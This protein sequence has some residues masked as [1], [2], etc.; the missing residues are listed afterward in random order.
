MRNWA[1]YDINQVR[2]SAQL[3]AE[4]RADYL[5]KYGE[6]ISLDCKQRYI[7]K[8]QK[9]IKDMKVVKKEHGFVLKEKYSG[10][11]Y[12]GKLYRNGDLTEKQALYL[13]KNHPAKEQ[14]FDKMPKETKRKTNDEPTK[15][16]LLEQ[17][18]ELGYEGKKNVKKDVLIEFINEHT[19]PEPEPEPETETET[20]TETDGDYGDAPNPDHEEH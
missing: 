11:R 10:I 5:Q 15:A 9:F 3:W 4:F 6:V 8:F 16:E 7:S 12:K 14:L 20:E 18:I 17:A 1:K 19:E 2:N 13:L